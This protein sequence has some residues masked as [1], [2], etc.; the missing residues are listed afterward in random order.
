M[1]QAPSRPIPGLDEFLS[2][3]RV[4]FQRRESRAAMERYL[5]GVVDGPSEYEL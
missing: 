1:P 3:F 2:D 4:L 5:T